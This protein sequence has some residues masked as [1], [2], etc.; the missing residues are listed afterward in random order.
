MDRAI[1]FPVISGGIHLS[2]TSWSKLVL[3]MSDAASPVRPAHFRQQPS[4]LT[5]IGGQHPIPQL[6]PPEASFPGGR[7]VCAI[8]F[9]EAPI[10]TH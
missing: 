7:Q 5:F 8:H 6:V 1:V 2:E 4:R 10:G 9:T 3:D